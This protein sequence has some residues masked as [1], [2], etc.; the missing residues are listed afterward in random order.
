MNRTCAW[1]SSRLGGRQNLRL[2]SRVVFLNELLLGYECELPIRDESP[3]VVVAVVVVVVVVVLEIFTSLIEL[4][5]VVV[6]WVVVV[7]VVI[8]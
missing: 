8:V 7:V 4:V 6:A 5:V 3:V 2:L 1:V